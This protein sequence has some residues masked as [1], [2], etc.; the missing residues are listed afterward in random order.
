MAQ[1]ECLTFPWIYLHTWVWEEKKRREKAKHHHS[2]YQL[3]GQSTHP[4]QLIR[5][6][7]FSLTATCSVT[8]H[9][10]C[11]FLFLSCLTCICCASLH[12]SF[13]P[14]VSMVSV[15]WTFYNTICSHYHHHHYPARLL[16][17]RAVTKLLHPCLSLASLWMVP[18]LWFTFFIS[19][20]TVPRQVVFGRPRFCHPSGVLWIVTLVME[21]TSLHSMCLISNI[22]SWWWWSPYLLDGSV[23]RGHSWRWFLA[24]RCVGFSQGLSCERTTAWHSHARSSA[25]TLIHT[26]GST[27]RCSGRA[28][29][30]MLYCDDLQNAFRPTHYVT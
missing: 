28:S 5:L 13:H 12:F 10:P 21:L 2:K 9:F 16:D 15:L 11:H 4:P 3:E 20:S 30:M 17:C 14:S 26:E 1:K 22:A 27:I 23:L 24:K 6:S 8:V 7:L 19:A 29:A 25:S 18:Q